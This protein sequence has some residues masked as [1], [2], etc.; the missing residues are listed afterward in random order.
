MLHACFFFRTDVYENYSR[1]FNEQRQFQS[2]KIINTSVILRVLWLI[3]ILMFT[4]IS[5]G[6]LDFIHV[7]DTNQMLINHVFCR[8]HYGLQRS[9]TC[10][11]VGVW[12][13][14]RQWGQIYDKYTMVHGTWRILPIYPHGGGEFHRQDKRQS[15]INCTLCY[16]ILVN[17]S[18]RRNNIES[19]RTLLCIRFST[20]A[21]YPIFL[22]G[23]PWTCP[24]HRKSEN[25]LP[26]KRPRLWFPSS[27]DRCLSPKLEYL[28]SL[29]GT[30]FNS[31]LSTDVTLQP[32]DTET[33][34]ECFA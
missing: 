17:F 30:Y 28:S 5:S 27:S 14:N 15:R 3:L 8:Y 18:S 22:W 32:E 11:L 23:T 29:K 4:Y 16:L 26:R 9:S 25:E 13:Y 20:P 10:L 2:N 12:I 31:N 33:H 24:L 34:D 21:N 1:V 6:F 7:L 19:R